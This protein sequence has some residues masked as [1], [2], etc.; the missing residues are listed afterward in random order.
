MLW[1]WMATKMSSA[2]PP[3][4]KMTFDASRRGCVELSAYLRAHAI[5]S[6]SDVTALRG[7]HAH[8]FVADQRRRARESLPS[9][10]IHRRGGQKTTATKGIVATTFDGI[11]VVLRA[12][13]ESAESDRV[14]LDRAFIVAVPHGGGHSGRRR[15]FPDEAAKALAD[16]TN[17][18]DLAGRDIDDRGLRDIWETL[19][20]TGRRASEILQ[21]RMDCLG[22]YNG[23]PMLWHDQTK[24][25]SYDQAIRI[26][27]DLP[28]LAA[29]PADD[30]WSLPAAP[31]PGSHRRQTRETGAI[32]APGQQPRPAPRGQLRLV[33]Q[34]LPPMDRPP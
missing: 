13:M 26:P 3:R 28:S 7:E 31:R 33:Q 10:A 18:Q 27:E 1:D 29:T 25:A 30:R 15:P 24:V 34:Q 12:A 2:V 23:L 9:L 22:R 6:G 17:L 16:E 32:P 4:S 8:A 14:E 21:L 11:R 19:I 20:I 5:H